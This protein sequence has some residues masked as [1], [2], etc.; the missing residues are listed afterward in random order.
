MKPLGRTVR[1]YLVDGSPLGLIVAEII[2]WTGK[3]LTFPR[4]RC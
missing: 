2:G 1:L 4:G 3:I